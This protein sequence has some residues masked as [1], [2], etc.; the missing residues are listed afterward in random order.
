MRLAS[1]TISL[2]LLALLLSGV[3]RS[4]HTCV[5][6]SAA[7][8]EAGEQQHGHGHEPA[9]D[10]SEENSCLMFVACGASVLV[11]EASFTSLTSW[12]Y[13]SKEREPSI[14]YFAPAL[15]HETPPPRV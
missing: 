1:R 12:R 7:A 3:A 4:Q 11:R 5:M 2:M 9:T 8:T 14:M 6:A 15:P 13:Q 10:S